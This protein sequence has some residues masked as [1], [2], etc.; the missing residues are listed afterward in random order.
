MYFTGY[1]SLNSDVSQ[2]DAFGLSYDDLIRA[3]KNKI[4]TYFSQNEKITKPT[5]NKH[6]EK[7]IDNIEVIERSIGDTPCLLLKISSYRTKLFDV[8]I[9]RNDGN[10]EELSPNDE[11]GSDNF[12]VLVV[13]EL[14]NLE[15][16]NSKYRW[17]FYLYEDPY[18]TSEEHQNAFKMVLKNVIKETV[19]HMRL[20]D[21]IDELRGTIIPNMSITLFSSS[22]T[23]PET[24]AKYTAHHVKTT[25]KAKKTYDFESVPS[26]S[27][28]DTISGS[29]EA[30][31][32]KRLVKCPVGNKNYI[33]TQE[34]NEE[35]SNI[36]ETIERAFNEEIN[37]TD[38]DR[39]KLFEEDFIIEKLTPIVYSYSSECHV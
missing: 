22:S 39:N 12:F 28:D 6:E 10:T 17:M 29:D 11:I 34:R 25:V 36:K 26:N 23:T 5:R 31:W 18:K 1:K 24:E 37:Y 15:A 8:S 3:L 19:E 27:L 4:Q 21:V 38:G 16:N 30:P 14:V 35:I 20:P 9:K 33:I 13:P 2:A 32:Y 7:V